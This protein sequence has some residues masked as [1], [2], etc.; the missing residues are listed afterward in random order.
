M[1]RVKI[2]EV[3]RKR[4]W[5][6]PVAC[7]VAL[8]LVVPRVATVPAYK[9]PRLDVVLKTMWRLVQNGTLL[10]A[11]GDSLVRLAIAFVLGAVLGTS[12]GMLIGLNRW[13]RLFIEPLVAFFQS[14]AGVAWI[15]LAIVWFGFGT[16][17]ALFVIGNVIFFVVLYNTLQGVEAIQPIMYHT[18]HTLGAS[19]LE[20]IREVVV[21]GALVSVLTG[22][23]SGLAFGWRALIAVEMIAANTGLGYLSL[24]AARDYRGD[25]VVGTIIVVGLIWLLM[26]HLLLG[27][28]QRRTVAR[29][30]L[31]SDPL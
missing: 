28:L 11:T 6:I 26:D 21:P 27:P 17:P 30:G 13:V 7:L 18:L 20:I 24:D 29:W 5:L 9:L 16:G 25:V 10:R 23:R 8:W 22:L 31:V 1:K 19:R 12:I 14:V 15:P 4:L 3:A 2:V